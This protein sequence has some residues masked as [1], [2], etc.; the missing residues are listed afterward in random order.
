MSTTRTTFLI[1]N[2][3]C[4]SCVAHI[5]ETLFDLEP[6]PLSISYSIIS[7]SVSV[8]HDVSLP[9]SVMSE[10]LEAASFEV[11][12]LVSA[13]DETLFTGE[14][15]SEE[16]GILAFPFEQ[17][18]QRWWYG[19]EDLDTKKRKRHI[20]SCKLCLTN[21]KTD[22]NQ[23]PIHD[24]DPFQSP[25]DHRALN[26]LST[27]TQ[28]S[29]AEPFVVVDPQQLAE[30][31]FQA[32]ITVE[33]MT[34]SSCVGK[35]TQVLEAKP[36]VKNTNV[37]LLTNSATVTFYGEGHGQQ[38]VE[39]INDTGYEAS[40]EHVEEMSSTGPKATS[41]K[42]IWRGSY[43]I[44]GMTC[45]SC[46]GN[47]TRALEEQKW[48]I[49]IDVN[50]IS[51]SATITFNGK[52]HASE[53]ESI[54]EDVGYDANLTDLVDVNSDALG[55]NRRSAIIRVD[56]MYCEHCPP[57]VEAAVLDLRQVTIEKPPTLKDPTIKISYIPAAPD[58][59]IRHILAS[60]SAADAA[61][62]ASIYHPTSL[63]ERSQRMLIREKQQ[64]LYRVILS[65]AAAIPALIIGIIYMNLVSPDNSG[66]QYL[67]S[68]IAGISRA[69][70]A[71]FI[72]ATPVYFLA[73]DIFH[74]R[75]FKELRS[76]WRPGSPTPILRRFYRFGSMNMLISFGTSI[77]YFASIA[78]MAVAA[79]QSS[80]TN[81]GNAAPSYFDSVVFLTMFLLIGRLIEAYSKAKTGDAIGALGKLRANEA[82]LVQHDN[83]N[84]GVVSEQASI[85]KINVD[86]LEVGDIVR[87]LNGASPP[88]DGIVVDGQS[89]FDES[90][91]TGESKPVAK[92]AGD[93]VFCGTINKDGPV[94]IRATGISGTSL[95]DQIMKAVREGQTRRAPVER[96]ADILTGYFVPVV[97][98]IVIVTWITWLALGL[99]GRLPADYRDTEVGGWPFWSLQFAI[100]TFVVACPCGI[101]LAAPTALFVGGGLAARYGILVKGGGEA[102]Q[103]ASNL[104]VV[105]FDKTGTLTQGGEPKINGYRLV[106]SGSE[107]LDEETLLA[108][109]KSLEGDSNHP[110]AKAIVAF[111]KSRDTSM[112]KAN[113]TEEIP[114]KGMKGVFSTISDP[115]KIIHALAGNEAFLT[116]YGISLT[117]EQSTILDT[118]KSQGSSIA[119]VAT[120]FTLIDSGLP[121]Y[122]ISALFATSDPL[123]LESRTIVT[124]LRSRGISVWMISGDNPLTAHAVAREVG[125]EKSNVIAGV[126]PTQK[127]DKIAYLQKSLTKTKRR[128]L[129]FGKRVELTGQRAT[130]AMVGDG[131]NDSPAL[132]LADVGI[133]IGSGSDVAISSADFVL[134]SSQLESVLTLIDL[135]RAVFRRIK[136]NFAWALIYN[137]IALPVA[138][139][140]LFPIKSNGS[141]IRLDPVWAALAMA[142]SSISVVS[143]SLLLRSPLPGVGFRPQAVST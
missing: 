27:A 34:C 88:C 36:W 5:E 57:R 93:E 126:L 90:S 18:I 117:A 58:L 28:K 130:V 79:S 31:V 38:L 108:V 122:T 19:S 52:D 139:G 132:T 26:H 33:G 80:K 74:R 17:A 67:E 85:R 32:T 60:I 25:A 109:V 68:K 12:N 97:T 59:T 70:L 128:F 106:S 111:C 133:A 29:L 135:S 77:A 63:E 119:L 95:L 120:G 39:T 114:G 8:Y 45:S 131:I 96:V 136:F 125:I 78:E 16:R 102:F 69:Q 99:S 11:Y 4:S 47:I 84:E 56:G 64:I 89:K 112:I 91:L 6:K 138:A 13:S 86:L 62:N 140:V 9:R 48:V 98:L 46:V 100:A 55:R 50:L 40:L 110:I 127:A 65:V 124:S 101:G 30:R 22:E 104:D 116:D 94:S 118:W 35:V 7:H 83:D 24:D 1:P 14:F 49:S 143:S 92:D 66:R 21:G 76:L 82:L 113:S 103:E 129:G 141:H 72:I 81:M 115:S 53:I 44:V 75:T 137:L 142:M 71:S 15:D 20:E 134:V 2:L 43:A 107:D 10:A 51:N 3:H 42:D 37:S 105:V 41:T 54:I 121:T 73:A 123:R 23:Q 87:V 61:F